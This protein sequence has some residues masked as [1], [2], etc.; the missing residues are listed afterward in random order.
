MIFR[1]PATQLKSITPDESDTMPLTPKQFEKLLPA[2]EKLNA[3]M[4]YNSAKIGQH[5]RA[6]LLVQRWTLVC[7][8]ICT[9]EIVSVTRKVS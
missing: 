2:T 9:S 8:V 4:R 5:L 1:D 3:D 6:R 7:P